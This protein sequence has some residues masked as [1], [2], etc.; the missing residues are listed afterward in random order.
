MQTVMMYAKKLEKAGVPKFTDLNQGF[1]YDIFFS[2]IC[3]DTAPTTV[4]VSGM[5]QFHCFM[6]VACT[7]PELNRT[8]TGN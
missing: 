8:V 1:T 4:P 6:D 3:D 5:S 2:S 7:E